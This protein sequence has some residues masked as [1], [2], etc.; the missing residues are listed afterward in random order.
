ME[1]SNW[2]RVKPFMVRQTHHE[3]LNSTA[4]PLLP[5]HYQLVP[6][7]RNSAKAGLPQKGGPRTGW[8]RTNQDGVTDEDYYVQAQA[9]FFADNLAATL[10]GILG[11]VL[12]REPCI[13]RLRNIE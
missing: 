10:I 12:F 13:D 5:A 4:L 6:G 3:R 2:L 1:K 11:Y 9:E 7:A 8:L